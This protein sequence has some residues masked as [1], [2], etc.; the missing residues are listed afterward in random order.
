MSGGGPASEA[1]PATGEEESFGPSRVTQHGGGSPSAVP[2]AQ[3]ERPPLSRT[4][5][6]G[7]GGAYLTAIAPHSP[8]S[9]TFQY[10]SDRNR[11][12]LSTRTLRAP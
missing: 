11:S 1:E 8:S 9:S 3:R 10:A 7:L 2:P 5:A 4:H 12:Q 6:S